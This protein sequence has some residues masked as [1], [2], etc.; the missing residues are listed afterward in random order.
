MSYILVVKDEG[1]VIPSCFS[2]VMDLVE[3]KLGTDVREYIE[4]FV[5]D[6]EYM[7]EEITPDEHFRDVLDYI[8]GGLDVIDREVNAKRV[9]KQEIRDET[10]SL[11]K[12]IER[13]LRKGDTQDA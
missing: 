13:E 7:N 10:E 11:R 4:A 9:A 2:D 1:A 12:T 3:E 8:S 6:S 5:D